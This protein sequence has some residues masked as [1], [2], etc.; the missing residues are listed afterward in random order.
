MDRSGREARLRS[1]R[2]RSRGRVRC[3]AT[4]TSP[5]LAATTTAQQRRRRRRRRRSSCKPAT[6]SSP[7]LM[8]SCLCLFDMPSESHRGPR[9]AGSRTTGS[10]RAST[11]DCRSRRALTSGARHSTREPLLL[12]KEYCLCYLERD[13]AC[14]TE[15]TTGRWREISGYQSSSTA[16]CHA[17]ERSPA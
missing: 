16:I 1:V 15:G 12:C 17:A 9:S 8:A 14:L 2:V 10:E 3:R 13:A 7:T 5:K 6:S 4:C 11:M